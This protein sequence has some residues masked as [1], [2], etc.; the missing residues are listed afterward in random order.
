[1]VEDGQQKQQNLV[2][3]S[4]DAKSRGDESS[5]VDASSS[6]PVETNPEKKKI[7]FDPNQFR[8]RIREPSA[9]NRSRGVDVDSA[10]TCTFVPT[11]IETDEKDVVDLND[12]NAF[13]S[14]WSDRRRRQQHGC[15]LDPL[16]GKPIA[17]CQCFEGLGSVM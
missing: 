13:W 1:M 5:I 8:S 2:T 3:E 10:A 12:P 6:T 14:L 16:T 4:N 9:Q 7:F 15:A 11:K 17:G